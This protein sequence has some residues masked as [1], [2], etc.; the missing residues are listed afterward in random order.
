MIKADTAF[1][2]LMGLVALGFIAAASAIK[3]SFLSDPVGPKIF[4]IAIGV[5]AL[6]FSA[7]MII[8]PDPDPDM[9]SRPAQFRLI[10]TLAALLGYAM[11][12]N[13]VGFI[14]STVVTAGLLSYLISRKPVQAVVVG[15]GLAVGIFCLFR[16]LL[17]LSLVA[18]PRGL[19]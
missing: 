18:W 4:P 14:P 17:G 10:A 9:P 6:L 1:G 11:T 13:Q 12:I 7:I 3:P 2:V 15:L 19:F 16:F 5:A 8:R